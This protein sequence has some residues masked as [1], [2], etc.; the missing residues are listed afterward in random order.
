MNQFSPLPLSIGVLSWRRP[1]LLRANLSLLK[2][3]AVDHYAHLYVVAQEATPEHES[4]CKEFG[5]SLNTF[6]DNRGIAGG[7]QRTFAQAPTEH[8]LHLEE[9]MLISRNKQTVYNQLKLSVEAL[10]K[11]EATVCFLRDLEKPGNNFDLT[12][13][14]KLYS[15][16]NGTLTPNLKGKLR[17]LKTKKLLGLALYDPAL[18]EEVKQTL[19]TW[20]KAG[21]ELSPKNFNW[22]NQA[23]MTSGSFLL[24][25]ILPY[26]YQN[27][28]SRL[29]NGHP[30]IERSLNSAWWRAQNFKLIHAK[31]CFT[32][33]G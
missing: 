6:A 32:H 4:I 18:P 1:H 13:Y 28:T 24:K 9:D 33:I 19:F 25:T 21:Y 20:H 2:N 22:T 17:P 27:P 10:Q 30:D 31:G 14:K 29:V 8:V 11:K 16:S 26:V 12:K 3:A 23:L 7:V 5:V 15:F